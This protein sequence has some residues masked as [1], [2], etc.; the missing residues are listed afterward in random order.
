MIRTRAVIIALLLL[1]FLISLASFWLQP[2]AIEVARAAAIAND[3]KADN[4]TMAG[5]HWRSGTLGVSQSQDVDFF[6]DNAR[7]P[8]KVRVKL[9]RP[10]YF[11][12]WRVDACGEV[13]E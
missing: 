10:V 8:K 2:S 1:L 3:W 6:V 13:P 7:P 12:G 11:L 9:S 5:F 4:L